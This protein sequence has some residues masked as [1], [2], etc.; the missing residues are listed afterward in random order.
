M[1]NTLS[2]FGV[3]FLIALALGLKG[4]KLKV[5]AF[6]SVLPDVDFILYS[7]FIFASSSLSHET[8]NQLF[9]LF[10]HREFT[11]SIL[12]IFLVTF[13]Y[14][15]RQRTGSLRLEGFNLFFPMF[16]WIILQPGKCVPSTRS[17]Q[18]HPLWEQFI[19][20]TLC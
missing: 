6:L 5:V 15:L 10:W 14:G 20:S 12:F 7:I 16:T 1:V 18:I 8:R 9:Y 19:S 2:H 17:V 13:L 3:G 4:N 11:H